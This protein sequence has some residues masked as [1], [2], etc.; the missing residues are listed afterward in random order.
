MTKRNNRNAK[1][2]ALATIGA[3]RVEP[4]E[5][6]ELDDAPPILSA[7]DAMAG[8]SFVRDLTLEAGQGIAGATYMGHGEPA[9]IADPDDGTVREVPTIL[10]KLGN[11]TYRMLSSSMLERRIGA[12]REGSIV[13]IANRGETRTRK[14]RRLTVWDVGVRS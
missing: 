9:E 1:S 14:G 5:L 4:G 6:A 3:E 2:D 7:T 10:L 13:A 12:V 8:F 11:V